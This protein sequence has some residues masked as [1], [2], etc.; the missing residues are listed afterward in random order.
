MFLSKLGGG[1]ATDLDPALQAVL[2][3]CH[4]ESAIHVHVEMV[5]GATKSYIQYKDAD[6]GSGFVC[7]TWQGLVTF[8]FQT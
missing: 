7:G 2:G 6:T 8:R 3:T 1:G 4:G 5:I